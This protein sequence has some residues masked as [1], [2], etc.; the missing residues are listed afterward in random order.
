MIYYERAKLDFINP[1][2]TLCFPVTVFDCNFELPCE[3]EY[4]APLNDKENHN[5]T[6]RRVSAEELNLL[7][8]PERDHSEDSPKGRMSQCI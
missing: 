4:S 1:A 6:W 7:G 2:C 8:G 3:L 5:R